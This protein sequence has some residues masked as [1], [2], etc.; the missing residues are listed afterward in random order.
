[1]VHVAAPAISKGDRTRSR[2]LDEAASLASVGGI[3]SVTLGHLAERLGMSK[4]GLFAHFDS[5]EALQVEILDRAAT[6]FRARVVDP[7]VDIPDKSARLAIFFKLWLDWIENPVSAVAVQF[8][9]PRSSSTT[10]PARS[11]RP[12]PVITASST[13]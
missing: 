7:L 8:W 10:C 9:P 3:G 6:Q 4:S 2:I 5:K 1:M 11:A 12:R 13:T